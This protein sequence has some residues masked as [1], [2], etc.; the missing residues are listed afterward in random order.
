MV[1]KHFYLLMKE[2]MV[3]I[4]IYKKTLILLKDNIKHIFTLLN[5]MHFVRK[6]GCGYVS[7]MLAPAYS[8]V[9]VY[10]VDSPTPVGFPESPSLRY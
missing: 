4:I 6:D 9:N 3:I 5:K 1:V 2:N 8:L 10:I 7:S